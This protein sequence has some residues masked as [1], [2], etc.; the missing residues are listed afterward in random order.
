M[1]SLKNPIEKR[2]DIL[3]LKPAMSDSQNNGIILQ[4]K[5]SERK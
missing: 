1:K 5:L 4:R 2:A 3:K